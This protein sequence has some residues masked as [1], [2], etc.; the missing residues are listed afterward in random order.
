MEVANNPN[1]KYGKYPETEAASEPLQFFN[2]HEYLV[3]EY[4]D[5]QSNV[6]S[7]HKQALV[8]THFPNN[9]VPFDSSTYR[10]TRIVRIPRAYETTEL[11]YL[12]PQ[13]S[14][15]LPGNE[16]ASL[17]EA[18][19]KF[20]A[21]GEYDNNIFGT[22][23]YPPLIPQHLS[24][25]EYK[26]IV[27]EVNQYL[28]EA[29]SPFKWRVFAENFLDVVTGTLYTKFFNRF[30]AENRSQAKLHE[31]E[32]FVSEEINGKLFKDKEIR[33]ISP[34]RSGYLSVCCN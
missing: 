1:S 7:H 21:A 26:M 5:S 30:I 33:L 22:T 23:S 16:P 18:E 3:N 14:T 10:L 2:Y 13:F 27:K 4:A 17:K 20:I 19:D 34:R 31:L 6:A 9:Y 15:Y 25:E 29:F 11:S 8:V 12:V 32:T 24:E 28:Y